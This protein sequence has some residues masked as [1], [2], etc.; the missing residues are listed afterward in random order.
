MMRNLPSKV[1]VLRGQTAETAP[2]EAGDEMA[3][4]IAA[5]KQQARPNS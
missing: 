1:S 2:A 3:A 5:G 4:A